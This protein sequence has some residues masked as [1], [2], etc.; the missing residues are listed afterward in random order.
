MIYFIL[1]A[2]D[3]IKHIDVRL[4]N[5][6]GCS[7]VQLLICFNPRRRRDLQLD[8]K[9]LILDV[10][11]LFHSLS[12]R[13]MKLDYFLLILIQIIKRLRTIHVLLSLW[14]NVMTLAS[15][16]KLVGL[17]CGLVMNRPKRTLGLIPSLFFV[18]GN[19]LNW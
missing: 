3:I 8:V 2:R 11:V 12:L 5:L 16:L 4:L 7:V 10:L 6:E 15:N 14:Q 9:R 17:P 18:V 1:S 13:L 19:N